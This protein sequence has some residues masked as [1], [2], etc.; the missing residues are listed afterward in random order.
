MPSKH[1]Q[2]T[3][4]ITVEEREALKQ[5]VEKS[6]MTASEFRRHALKVAVESYG[7]EF[8]DNM[9]KRGTYKRE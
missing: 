9:P 1:P 7:I 3:V 8:P 6:G 5:A 4:H 2:I